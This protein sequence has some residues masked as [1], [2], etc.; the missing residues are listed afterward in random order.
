MGLLSTAFKLENRLQAQLLGATDTDYAAARQKIQNDIQNEKIVVYTYGLSPFSTE[1]TALLDELGV[2]YKK[3]EVGL[4]W[5]LLDKEAST[6]RAQL[7]EMTG[8]SSLP[9]VFIGGTHVGGLFT[10]AKD[11]QYPGLAGLRESGELFAMLD[12]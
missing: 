6:L 2:D 4:E 7:L 9:Q 12:G 10:G 1:T 3:V 11:G 5:F 8:Q